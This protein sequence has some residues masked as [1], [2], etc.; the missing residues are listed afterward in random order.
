MTSGAGAEGDRGTGRFVNF[1]LYWTYSIHVLWQNYQGKENMSRQPRKLAETGFYHI[2]FRGVNHCHVFEA[3]EDCIK[4]LEVFAKVKEAH[5]F[6]LYAYCLLD[7]HVHL[8][9]KERSLG[10]IALVMQKLLSP[11]AYW[12]NNK[13]Q[14]SGQLIANRYRSECVETDEYLLTLVRYIHQNPLKAGITDQISSYR[15]SSYPEYLGKREGMVSTDFVLTMFSHDPTRAREEFEVFHR[16][17][18]NK[19]YSLPNSMKKSEQQVRL[20]ITSALAGL[21]PN[22][23]GSLAKSERDALLVMLRQQGF[24]IRQI[25]RVTGVSRGVIYKCM[26]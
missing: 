21:E 7:N 23:V 16:K 6:E 1:L 20:E 17:S 3:D 19:D 8:L 11:Y 15:W 12:F 4:F 26:K 2:V 13:Y 24:S 22:S 10:D 5:S 18:D 14:R 9:L 25:E